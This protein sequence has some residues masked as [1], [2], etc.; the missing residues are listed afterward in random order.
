MDQNQENL[1]LP[2]NSTKVTTFLSQGGWESERLVQQVSG[3]KAQ[4]EGKTAGR[5]RL[6]LTC[7][8]HGI[9]SLP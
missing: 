4:A 7:W 6:P 3:S 1:P 5:D 9:L 8:S 2:T